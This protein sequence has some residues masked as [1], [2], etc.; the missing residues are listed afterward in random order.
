MPG[1]LICQKTHADF[2]STGGSCKISTG[3]TLPAGGNISQLDFFVR[4][5]FLLTGSTFIQ[6]QLGTTDNQAKFGVFDA[7]VVG[8]TA[9][10]L[11]DIESMSEDTELFITLIADDTL[12]LNDL[13][14]GIIAVECIIDVMPGLPA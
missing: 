11:A 1:V 8:N 2:A 6:G 7:T 14:S 3:Y 10:D 9:I 5:P 4:S 12:A 13:G